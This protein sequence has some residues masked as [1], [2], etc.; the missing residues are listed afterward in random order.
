MGADEGLEELRDALL[1]QILQRAAQ[2]LG[3]HGIAQ[4]HPAQDFRGEARNA[5]EGQALALA[6]CIADA[7][8]AVIGNADD[9]AGI[10]LLRQFTVAGHEEHGIVDG[11]LLGAAHLGQLHAALEAPGA[12]PQEGDPVAMV[13]VHI[14]LH[15]EDE[16]RHLVFRWLDGARLGRLRARRRREFR[17]ALQQPCHA[18]GAQ[19]TAEIDRRHM[20]F[21]ICCGIE[22]RAAGPRELDFFLEPG[23]LF[24]RGGPALVDLQPISQQIEAA[25]VIGRGTQGPEHRRGVERQRLLDLV[26]QLEG[27]AALTVELVDEGDDGHIAQPADLEQLQGLGFDALGRVQHHHRGIDRCQGAIGVL[28]E[29]LVAGGIEQ[30]EDEAVMLEGHHRGR[31]RNPALLLDLHPVGTGAPSLAARAHRAR[32]LDRAPAQEKLFRQRRFARIGMSDDGKGAPALGLA[33][34]RGTRGSDAMGG[35]GWHG[36]AD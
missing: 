20:A 28:A 10:G 19:G 1:R 7:Q 31:D 12:E 8:G 34:R 30:I 29:I 16:A 2:M 17:Q 13:R 5:G 22:P 6:Q 35:L 14:G 4:A 3:P 15:L 23:E 32:L 11:H 9:V 18:M 24:G 36:V 21:A 26:D 33:E 25:P 27:V